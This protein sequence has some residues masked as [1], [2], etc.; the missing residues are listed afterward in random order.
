[1]MIDQVLSKNY[2]KLKGQKLFRKCCISSDIAISESITII[3]IINNQLLLIIINN[4]LNI[5]AISN[6][7]ANVNEPK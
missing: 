4:K 5:N 2:C 1:M 3:I 7:L 6:T